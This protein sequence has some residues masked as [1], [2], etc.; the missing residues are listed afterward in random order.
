M[1]IFQ[2]DL[3]HSPPVPNASSTATEPILLHQQINMPSLT[4]K[5]SEE[6]IRTELCEGPVLESPRPSTPESDA[7][8]ITS[9]RA[10]LI[11]RLKRGES[12]TW[13]PNRLL[14]S[15]RSPRDGPFAHNITQLESLFNNLPRPTTPRS[16][17]PPSSSSSLLPPASI[18]PEKLGGLRDD[19]ER[20]RE[21]LSIQRPRS[22][23]H[24]GDFTEDRSREK[25][26]GPQEEE[27]EGG[28]SD[29]RTTQFFASRN[30]W[31][32]TSPPRDFS[33]FQFDGRIPFVAAHDD[34]RSV[35]SSLSSSFSSSFVYKPPTSPLVQSESNDDADLSIPLHGIDIATSPLNVNLRRHTLNS[36]VPP[37]F[38]VP[39]LSHPALHRQSSQR[40]TALP[41]QAHQ[42]RRSLTSAPQV[43]LS[44]TSPQTPAFLRPRRPSFNAETSPLQH[45]SMVGSY[46]E[47]IL[48]GR[49][50]TTPSKPLNFLAQIGVLGL[51]KC[52]SSLRCPAHVTLPFPAVFYSYGGASQG[53]VRS[54]DGPSPYVGQIDLE[55]GLPNPE[56]GQR[57]RRKL[58]A[59]VA[60]RR[61]VEDDVAMGD[62]PAMVDGSDREARKTQRARRRSGSPRAP[63]GGSYRIPE[64]G[65]IQ[66]IIKNPNKTA[67]KLFLVPY[68]LAGMEPGTKTFIRQRSY[69][70]GPIIENAPGLAEAV[71]SDRPILRY[72]VHLH[73]CC[74]A[75]GRY[76][77]YKS[78]RIVF[79]NRVPDGKEK[80][81]NE[82]TCPEPRYTPYKPI[83]A[84]HSPLSNS[85]G[86]AATLAAEK[87]F[88]RRSAGFSLGQS[89]HG[90]DTSDGLS[91]SPQATGKQP[92]P[93]P[94]SFG[95]NNQPV[96]T[97]PFALPGR[98]RLGSNTSD[99]TNTTT[100]PGILSPQSSQPSRPT[101]KD[102]WEA[103]I[104]RYE[105]LNKG[106]VGYGGNLFAPSGRGSPGGTEGL[107]S[108][109]LRS[110]GVQNQGELSSDRRDSSE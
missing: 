100:T 86:P 98:A 65:Q 3:Y 84:M 92:S 31:I 50:S 10:E 51:G 66:I 25:Q 38:A 36:V 6:S 70:A 80:L 46:E 110:L 61:A 40:G 26:Q 67:V 97:I 94:F 75:K 27:V 35:P 109:R 34:Y 76:Y 29:R 15:P 103:H 57:S 42:P 43:T 19:D 9:D 41:Y 28:G 74:P 37:P 44:G 99:S 17:R 90:F 59:R 22:A 33:S 8:A 55:N 95:G 52:K 58:Q 60:E 108:R 101:T 102:G 18:T 24:S 72:L 7:A 87:A 107:L 20:V 91:Q 96:D 21:G 39:P 2:D 69:S 81:R 30:A 12:P 63:P 68:D 104:A 88:R 56:E 106:D 4:R 79:A 77:L 105:K 64:K 82:T 93:S 32:A 1:P 85:S 5:L 71:G 54:E 83:R 11:E 14:G 73:I 49:M 16:S 53:R 62:G 48:R 89:L 78:I 13:V 45:A 47:S 23:L